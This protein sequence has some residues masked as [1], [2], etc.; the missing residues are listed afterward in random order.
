MNAAADGRAAQTREAS[1]KELAATS[2]L[3]LPLEEVSLKTRSGPPR[4][5]PEDLPLDHW[6]GVLPLR[7]QPG[8]PVPAE[9]VAAP[10]P[11]NVLAWG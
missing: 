11:S 6:A 10:V 3:R 8:L 1:A 9:G 5:E 7:L 4:D 2:V